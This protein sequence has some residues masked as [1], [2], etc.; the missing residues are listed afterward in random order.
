MLISHRK[1]T[2]SSQLASCTAVW[3]RW[4]GSP[5][6]CHNRL[7]LRAFCMLSAAYHFKRTSFTNCALPLKCAA[8][9]FYHRHLLHGASWRMNH[10][11]NNPRKNSITKPSRPSG[12]SFM[13]LTGFD[14]T[15]RRYRYVQPSPIFLEANP[16]LE[17]SDFS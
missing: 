4:T 13:G 5:S 2:S 17:L 3:Q 1:P 15:L 6:S 10:H 8:T 16:Q 12:L 7:S 9:N 11:F 14:Y